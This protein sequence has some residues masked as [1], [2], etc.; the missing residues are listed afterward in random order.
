MQ[1]VT[2]ETGQNKV[3]TGTTTHPLVN[4]FIDA[5]VVSGFI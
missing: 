5:A 4:I 1:F 2:N 3:M